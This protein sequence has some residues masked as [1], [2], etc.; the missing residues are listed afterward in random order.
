MVAAVS[1]HWTVPLLGILF[2]VMTKIYAMYYH[3]PYL[4]DEYTK[5]PSNNLVKIILLPDLRA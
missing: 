1:I 5:A 4:T 2:T 3:H